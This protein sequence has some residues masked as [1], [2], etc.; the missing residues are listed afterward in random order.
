M[1]IELSYFTNQQQFEGLTFKN[2][3]PFLLIINDQEF[4]AEKIIRL[5]PQ[6][7]LVL[8]G[9]WQNKKVIIKVFFDKQARQHFNRE[10]IGYHLLEEK[11]I[12]IAPVFFANELSVKNVYAVIYLEFYPAKKISQLIENENEERAEFWLYQTQQVITKLHQVGLLQTDLH[13]NNFVLV[14]DDIYLLDYAS[15][16]QATDK[17]KQL[18]NIA[19]FYVQ[20]PANLFHLIKKLFFEYCVLCQQSNDPLLEKSLFTRIQALSWQRGQAFQKKCL[21]TSTDFVASHSSTQLSVY[22]RSEEQQMLLAFIK[23]PEKMLHSLP[24]KIL[25]AGNTSTVLQVMMDDKWY[26]VKRYNVKSWWHFFTHCWRK[27]RAIKSWCNANLLQLMNIPTAKPLAVIE[28]KV[29]GLTTTS[30][31]LIE[32]LSDEILLDRLLITVDQEIIQQVIKILNELAALQLAHGDLKA[33][34]FIIA[35]ERAYLIDLD[36]MKHYRKAS[37]WRRA[38][39]KDILR[40][41]KNWWLYPEILQAFNVID[42]DRL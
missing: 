23:D 18:E 15:I 1:A 35:Q 5:L 9:V 12:A 32:F 42:K 31:V 25:K 10:L 16:K 7:R 40:F 39:K 13:L 33:N 3:K 8:S 19:L 21:R 11:G 17:K 41:R 22:R 30:Y 38:F 37:L 24:T 2:F 6:K 28:N 36:A 34:N 27:S 20:F 4:L 29:L 26:I 14:G